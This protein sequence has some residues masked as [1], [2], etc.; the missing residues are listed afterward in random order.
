MSGKIPA[1]SPW[2]GQPVLGQ[3]DANGCL[4]VGEAEAGS[5]RARA[6]GHGLASA[7]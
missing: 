5:V 1:V 2:P 6:V 4:M 7:E 3:C